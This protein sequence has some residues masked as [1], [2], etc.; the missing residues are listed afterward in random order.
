MEDLG[1][2]Y[3]DAKVEIIV[4][5]LNVNLKKLNKEHKLYEQILKAKEAEEIH[6][7]F[8]I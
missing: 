3:Y 4:N 1:V 2:G 8:T 6:F 5:A 7:K